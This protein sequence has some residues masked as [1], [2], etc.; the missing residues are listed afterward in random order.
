M[1]LHDVIE[2]TLVG[3][4]IFIFRPFDLPSPR[5][6]SDKKN[7]YRHF[8][9]SQSSLFFFFF[10]VFLLQSDGTVPP[11]SIVNTRSQLSSFVAAH[12]FS[13]YSLPFR[14]KREFRLGVCAAANFTV[15]SSIGRR[16]S[17]FAVRTAKSL[18]WKIP[19]DIAVFV[20]RRVRKCV[21]GRSVV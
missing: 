18:K 2:F 20:L 14:L 6:V 4:L 21:H 3:V 5:S 1:D 11:R 17:S 10:L 19:D 12:L 7:R 15:G 16:P 9:C 13:R 8:F